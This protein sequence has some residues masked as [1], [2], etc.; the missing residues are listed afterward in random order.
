MSALADPPTL[1][2]PPPAPRPARRRIPGRADVRTVAAPSDV[3]A[4]PGAPAGGRLTLGGATWEVYVALADAPDNADLKFTFDGPAG[5]L[6]I[7]MPNGSVHETAAELLAALVSAFLMHRDMEFRPTGTVTLRRRPGR[8]HG[9]RADKT[10]YIRTFEA[11]RGKPT[12]SVQDGDPPP[13]LAI[14]V[15]VTSP[16]VDKL[17]IYAAL[18]VPEVWVWEDAAIT[19]R[20][21]TDGGTYRVVDRSVE[22]EGF[23]TEF[24]AELTGRL[25]GE[26]QNAILKRFAARLAADDAAP[27]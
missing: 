20:R 12:I 7:E 21:L 18:G 24:A 4:A 6:E 17:P 8:G 23:P 11:V 13:D 9:L 25:G 19:V 2:L 15:D 16:G 27:A 14:E 3:T 10:Y 1:E 5:L 22:V 26:G